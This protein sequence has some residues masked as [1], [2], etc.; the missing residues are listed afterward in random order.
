MGNHSQVTVASCLKVLVCLCIFVQSLVN[1]QDIDPLV[2]VTYIKGGVAKGAVCLDGS[3]GAYYFGQGF[4]DGIDNWIVYLPGG[5]WC[6]SEEN[7]LSRSKYNNNTGTTKY[8]APKSFTTF[9][10][11]NRI[12][13]PDFYNWNRV[14]IRYCDGAS[15]M[16]DV[17]AVD[18]VTKLYRRGRR[19]FASVL[20]ELITT[21]AM[22]NAANALLIGDSAGGLATILNCDRFH[23]FLPDACRVKCVSDAG[24]FIRGKDLPGAF[25]HAMDYFSEVVKYH[26]LAEYLPKSC[27][28]RLAPELCFFPENVVNDIKTPLFLLNS[29]FDTYQI[30]IL[31]AP[32]SPTDEG[33]NCTKTFASLVNCTP[34]QLH[35]IMDFRTAF[36]K[37]LQ[38]LDDNP[39]RGLFI[40]SCY[41]HSISGYPHNWQGSP[42]LQNKTVQ[43]AIGDWYFE[44][45][46]VQFIDYQHRHP[47]Y[48]N[49]I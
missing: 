6:Y 23:S 9:L 4:E 28:Q 37:T 7:C 40:T 46:I 15:F 36:L 27:T 42:T 41:I 1:G 39:S 14:L 5:A 25:D 44:R 26:K 30:Y 22:G 29:D 11:Q 33:W 20:E 8:A 31:V 35:V 17:E 3:P 43:Q 45:N 21:K 49:G 18:P 16:A 13:N 19:I 38:G 34:D 24:F 47:I 2:N 12:I 10:S 32:N 48:C